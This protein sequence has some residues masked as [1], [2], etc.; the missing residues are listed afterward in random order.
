MEFV[1][2]AAFGTGGE[3]VKSVALGFRGFGSVARTEIGPRKGIEKEGIAAVGGS[4]GV[5]GKMEGFGGLAEVGLVNLEKS[6]GVFVPFDWS[7]RGFLGG[8]LE[9]GEGVLGGLVG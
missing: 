6:V 1:R 9:E 7:G 2:K 8:S 5:L 3:E 4:D